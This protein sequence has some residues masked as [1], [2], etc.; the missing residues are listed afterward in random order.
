NVIVTWSL[1]TN[2]IIEAEEHHTANLSERL[3]AAREIADMGILIGFHFHPIV[4]YRGWENDY[5]EI[6]D[7][8]LE[9]FSPEEVVLISL[10][11]L[12]FIKP[13]LKQLRR[14]KMDSKILQMPL[15][16]AEG[17]FSDPIETKRN[18]SV[19]VTRDLQKNGK[20]MYTFICVWKTNYYGRMFS[21]KSTVQPKSLKLI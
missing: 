1:N 10:G 17:K 19:M 9:N 7:F 11:T 4:E 8:I 15:T 16:D 2:I 13:V 21:E 12:T 3:H 20:M 18:C 5:H 14:R 6:I